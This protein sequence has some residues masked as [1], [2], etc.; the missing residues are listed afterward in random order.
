MRICRDLGEAKQGNAYHAAICTAAEGPTARTS[1]EAVQPQH[2]P[3]AL[4][5]ASYGLNM[6]Q[7][8]TGCTE[9][10]N[11]TVLSFQLRSR[12]LSATIYITRVYTENFSGAVP[13]LVWGHGPLKYWPTP[14]ILRFN[15][16]IREGLYRIPVL[17]STNDADPA[18]IFS[19][20]TAPCECHVLH[21]TLQQKKICRCLTRL[22]DHSNFV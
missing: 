18:P 1:S 11:S 9:K 22:N 2:W 7:T 5:G 15:L 16:M 4:F 14:N 6:N 10:L 21:R 3:E 17:I 19:P 13:L 12:L 8:P 20:R